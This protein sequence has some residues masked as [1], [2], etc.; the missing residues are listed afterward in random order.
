MRAASGFVRALPAVLDGVEAGSWP[1]AVPHAALRAA[2]PRVWAETRRAMAGP[3]WR[4]AVRAFLG[5]DLVE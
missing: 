2:A 1:A 3:A 4:R 5:R